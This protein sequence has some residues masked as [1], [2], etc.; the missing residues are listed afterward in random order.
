MQT[1]PIALCSLFLCPILTQSGGPGQDRWVNPPQNALRREKPR[2]YTVGL[3]VDMGAISQSRDLVNP[4]SSDEVLIVIATVVVAVAVPRASNFA[5][6]LINPS[7]CAP[8]PALSL[9]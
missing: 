7:F 9:T 2:S 4:I 1:L 8:Q 6:L 3:A 5:V